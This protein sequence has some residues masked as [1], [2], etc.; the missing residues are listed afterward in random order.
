M[1]ARRV[2]PFLPVVVA[3]LLAGCSSS[4][5]VT[6]DV[7]TLR[8]DVVHA[9]GHVSTVS[10]LRRSRAFGSA[11]EVNSDEQLHAGQQVAV[12][13]DVVTSGGGPAYQLVAVPSGLFVQL[14]ASLGGKSGSY[15]PVRSDSDNAFVRSL[16]TSARAQIRAATLGVVEDYLRAATAAQRVGDASLD[17]QSTSEYVITV[18]NRRLARTGP[19]TPGTTTA[20]IPT[21]SV[22]LYLDERRRPVFAIQRTRVHGS[23]ILVALRFGDYGEHLSITTPSGG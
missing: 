20:G 7:A 17:G 8:A 21:F 4:K 22:H 18:D 14:P 2:L 11:T 10:V 12:R 13:A 6:V 23:Q 9:I 19:I 5:P 1:F 3:L 16:A 15:L